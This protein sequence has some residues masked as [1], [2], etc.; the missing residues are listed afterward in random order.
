M[1][2][3]HSTTFAHSDEGLIWDVIKH[4]IVEIIQQRTAII[5][6][7]QWKQKKRWIVGEASFAP[8]NGLYHSNYVSTKYIIISENRCAKIDCTSVKV[9]SNIISYLQM[10]NEK[11]LY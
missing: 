5:C 1:F 10:T 3:I 11:A 7:V 8:R 2:A 6:I 4:F 9:R